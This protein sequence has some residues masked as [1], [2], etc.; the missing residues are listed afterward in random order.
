MACG[1]KMKKTVIKHHQ[2]QI[3]LKIKTT[4]NPRPHFQLEFPTTR[5]AKNTARFYQKGAFSGASSETFPKDASD[6]CV[7]DNVYLK[8]KWKLILNSLRIGLL[9]SLTFL[10]KI[11]QI[12]KNEL[13]PN[14]QSRGRLFYFEQALDEPTPG[15]TRIHCGK[16]VKKFAESQ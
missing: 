2:N 9:Q 3:I 11:K 5:G 6:T 1:T 12:L 14:R 7:L 16:A 13:G 10:A 4:G 8:K 15:H